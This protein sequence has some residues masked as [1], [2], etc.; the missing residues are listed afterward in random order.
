MINFDCTFTSCEQ[1]Y[2][3]LLSVNVSV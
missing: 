2:Q 3:V 1:T